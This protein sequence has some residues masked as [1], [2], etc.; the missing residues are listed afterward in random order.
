MSASDTA[1]A[2]AVRT[3]LLLLLAASLVIVTAEENSAVTKVCQP[4]DYRERC[5]KALSS[6][7][8]NASDPLEIIKIGF[9]IA[10]KEIKDAIKNSTVIKEAAND[11]RSKK[12][13]D[14]CEKLLEYSI[15]ELHSSF[16][17]LGNIDVTKLNRFI[18]NLNVWLSG[19]VTYQQSCLD[20]FEN[21]TGN[22]GEKMKKALNTS[23]E[24]T[25]NGL[26]MVSEVQSLVT[27]LDL[28]WLGRRLLSQEQQSIDGFPS[29]VD[30]SR[31]RLLQES[32]PPKADVV[33]A[34]DGSGKYKTIGE[35]LKQIPKPNSKTFVIHIKAGVYKEKIIVD[36]NMTNVMMIGDGPTKTVITG[37]AAFVDGL[38]AIAT[39][40][41]SK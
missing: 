28:S 40:T 10:S 32:T 8:G 5:V 18:A 11:P 25:S 41:V 31:R 35:A 24:L 17:R 6:A 39:A 7:A 13:V 26:A 9:E 21:T 30:G 4:T 14:V 33:V 3:L 1:A 19:A 20:A 2:A 16:E 15:D 29:W 22:A 12:A 34:Q 38:P 36:R 27:Q 23:M 37:S